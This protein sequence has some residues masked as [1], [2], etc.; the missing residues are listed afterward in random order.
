MY[1]TF[2][3][4]QIMFYY[5]EYTHVSDQDTNKVDNKIVMLMNHNQSRHKFNKPQ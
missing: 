2:L 5:Y 3:L 1:Y 4:I